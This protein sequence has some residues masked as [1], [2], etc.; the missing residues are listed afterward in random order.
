[1]NKQ[2]QKTQSIITWRFALVCGVMLTVFMTL[3]AR[4]AFLQ[5]IEPDKAI[6]ENDK[7]TVRVEK[8]NVQRGMIFDRNGK[9]LAV[10]VPVVSVYADPLAIDK[11][12]AKKVLRKARKE[13]EDYK[14]LEQN[15]AE[16]KIRKQAWYDDELRWKE[17]ADVLRLKP[18]NVDERLRGDPSRR[19]VYLKRQVTAV[20]ANYIRQMRLPGVHLLD[21]SKRFYPSG[22]VTAH[23]IGVTD[24]DGKGIEGVE[25]MFDSALTGTAGKRTI[26][27]DA[28]GRE[29]QVLSEEQRVEPEDVYL[30]IDLRIQLLPIAR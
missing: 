15:D 25:R 5:V 24:I 28:Q 13:G 1:M 14:A 4:A 6:E 27:K 8:L 16:L 30:S 29:V 22:E 3:V 21:E 23:M 18:E 17:L 7:R 11:A 2:K 9:E 20:V 10:S 12:L 26:R 19:F